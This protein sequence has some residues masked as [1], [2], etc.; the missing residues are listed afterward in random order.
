MALS[1]PLSLA[2]FADH[3]P[4]VSL[5]WRLGPG[6]NTSGLASGQIY[7]KGVSPSLWMAEV[8]LDTMRHG[9]ADAIS[10]LV[11]AI[12]ERGGRFYM[13]SPARKF[14]QADP[15]GSLLGEAAPTIE[16]FGEDGRSLALNALPAGYV[17]SA[18]DFFAF[19]Y[20]LPARRAFH[21]VS[22]TV[23]ADSEGDTPAFE[24]TP[25]FNAGVEVGASV[26]LIAASCL[27]QI[28]PG[29]FEPGESR[30]ALTRGMRFAIV[31]AL[32]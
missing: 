27:A 25:H 9:E 21:R 18:G 16:A 32:L 2:A 11:E 22:E 31:Q 5:K 12:E 19:D 4:I 24:V 7:S 13:H 28:V 23:T 1:F 20:G 29:T 26:V 6:R 8:P 17:L 14:P 15:D 10:A 3:L 30:N